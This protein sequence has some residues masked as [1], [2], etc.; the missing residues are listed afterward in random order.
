MAALTPAS[1][2]VPAAFS[3]SSAAGLFTPKE[4]QLTHD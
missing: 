3:Q 2:S 4:I 1:T